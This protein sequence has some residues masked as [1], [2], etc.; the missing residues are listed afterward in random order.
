MGIAHG[1]RIV[2]TS[3]NPYDFTSRA[4]QDD[5]RAIEDFL[6]HEGARLKAAGADFFLFCANGAHRFVDA[7]VP[8]ISLPFVSIVE[9]TAKQVR[10]SLIKKVGLLGVRQTMSGRFY[11]ERLAACGVEVVTPSPADQDQI[12]EIIYTELIHNRITAASRTVFLRI[13]EDL[14]RAGAG[15]VILG[16]TEIPLLISPGDVA[17]PVFNTLEIHC[18]AV[19]A[20]AFEMTVN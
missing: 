6:V 13:I 16:C 11:H 7:V 2:M 1:A 18:Q 15:G 9:E 19:V 4:A 20:Y 3:L 14:A 5:P 10:A 12:H 17:I 8:R